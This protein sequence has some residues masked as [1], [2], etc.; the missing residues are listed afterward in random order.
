MAIEQLANDRIRT[1][2]TFGPVLSGA[3]LGKTAIQVGQFDGV[4]E[5][6]RIQTATAG[7]KFSFFLYDE[8]NAVDG[9]INNILRVAK[10]ETTLQLADL[11]VIYANE[12]SPQ[13]TVIWFDFENTGNTDSGLITVKLY[14]SQQ[15]QT[16]GQAGVLLIPRRD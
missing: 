4:I 12:D 16:P 7:T 14:I 3:S 15:A 11:N 5:A 10:A 8:Q 6:V 2:D 1:L 9:D 13:D